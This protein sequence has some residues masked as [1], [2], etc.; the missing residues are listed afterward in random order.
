M[1]GC[2]SYKSFCGYCVTESG[3]AGSGI[4]PA[5]LSDTAQNMGTPYF[6]AFPVGTFGQGKFCGMCV[7]VTF[8]GKT[9]TATVI[10]ECATC[11]T[12]GHLDLSLSAAAALGIGQGST[13]GDVTNGVTW[14]SVDCPVM[15]DIVSVYNNGQAGQIYFQN[16]TFPVASATAGGHTA[17]QRTGFWDFGASVA[18]QAVTLTDTVGHSI[19]GTIHS[20]GGSIDAQFPATCQ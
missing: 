20:N 7:D 9:I 3:S 11:P 14:K 15:N 2:S 16:V 6:V 4:C 8:G 19:N 5:G 17:T 13:A 10:D 12:A 18:G 1:A